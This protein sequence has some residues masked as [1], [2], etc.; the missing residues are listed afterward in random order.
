MKALVGI[1]DVEDAFQRLDSLTAE[2]RLIVSARS[3]EVLHDVDVKLVTI[4]AAI[5]MVDSTVRGLKDGTQYSLMFS[6]AYSYCQCSVRTQPF[7]ETRSKHGYPHRILPSII[8]SPSKSST[9]GLQS[10]FSKATYLKGGRR[11]VL[12]YGSVALARWLLSLAF[13][14][15][16]FFPI[17]QRDQAKAYF[18]MRFPN[19]C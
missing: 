3:L 15:I 13:A 6:C 14:I 12:Y 4:S 11:T 1:R 10:G 9:M 2:E 5:A 17:L 7:S 19:Y 18:G 16:N 8:T